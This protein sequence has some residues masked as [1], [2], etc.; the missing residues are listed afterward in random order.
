MLVPKIDEHL[1]DTTREYV[2]SITGGVVRM[3]TLINDL[4]EYSRVSSQG[5]EFK[6]VDLNKMLLQVKQNF[7]SRII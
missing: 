1:D 4:L 2:K 5:K 7:E 3:Q 6:S